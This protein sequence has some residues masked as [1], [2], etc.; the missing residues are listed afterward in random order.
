[1]RRKIGILCMISG[2]VLVALALF[3]LFYNRR[4]DELAGASADAA[5][6]RL[7]DVIVAGSGAGQ[8]GNGSGQFG[9]SGIGQ[10]GGSGQIGGGGAG[11]PA[12]SG[13]ATGAGQPGN[14]LSSAQHGN[15]EN[16]QMSSSGQAGGDSNAP[17]DSDEEAGMSQD[18]A[19]GQREVNGMQVEEIDGY[20][21]IGYLSIPSLSLELPIMSEWDYPRLRKAPCLY[22][23]SVYTDDFVI[24]AHNY[25]RHFGRLAELLPGDSV[26][27]TD[28]NG[29][30]HWFAVVEL[31]ELVPTA[32]EEMTDSG[33]PLTLFTCTYGGQ[34]RVALRCERAEIADY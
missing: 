1:M 20:G 9:G 10:P 16:G 15:S 14:S 5:L 21:Y 22:H 27:F 34:A 25:R 32:I 7:K 4:E 28:M 19:D 17:G 23:G 2:T 26:I 12:G 24:A 13:A 33:Y 30:A 29:T 18:T 31:Q 6:S 3:L 11:Q 8:S